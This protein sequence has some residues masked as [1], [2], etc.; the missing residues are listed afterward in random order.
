M[1]TRRFA[2]TSL[3]DRRKAKEIRGAYWIPDKIDLRTTPLME[4][5]S[6]QEEVTVMQV[7]SYQARRMMRVVRKESRKAK[8][9]FDAERT[10]RAEALEAHTKRIRKRMGI[11]D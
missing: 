6:G 3:N 11:K 7:T 4:N 5:D 9:S 2:A 10:A 8:G 1:T